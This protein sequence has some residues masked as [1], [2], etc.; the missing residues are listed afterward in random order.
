MDYCL[1]F[2]Q[3]FHM[4]ILYT[5]LFASIFCFSINGQT[6]LADENEGVL[7]F[8][9]IVAK[10]EAIFDQIGRGQG[11]GY[12]QFK[13]WEYWSNRSLRADGTIRSIAEA[14]REVKQF[15]RKYPSYVNKSVSGSYTE[16]GPEEATNTST[17]SSHL[18]RVSAMS[19]DINNSDHIIV[20]SPT[21]GVWRSIDKGNT[22]AT[23]F[24]DEVHLRVF[25]VEISHTN[26]DHYFVGTSI[27]VVY[28]T[29]AGVTWQS[30]NGI[31]SN[32]RINTLTMHPTNPNILFAVSEFDGRV[33]RSTNAG[34]N[35]TQV[36]NHTDRMYDLEFHPTDPSIVYTSGTGAVFKSTNTGVTFSSLSGP[37]TNNGA[38]MM[39]VTADAVDNLY[40]LQA[41]SSGGFG[42]LYVSEDQ[43]DSFSTASDN[44]GNDTN[45]MGYNLNAPNGQAP[46]DMDVVVSPTDKT[47]IHVA[48]TQTFKSTDEGVTW[49]QSTHWVVSNTTLPF[50]HADIDILIYQGNTL[51]AGTD[52]GIFYSTDSANSFVDISQGLSIRE[53]YRIGASET[54]PDRVSGGSQ[55]NGTGVLK[56]GTWFDYLGADGM[57]TL[58]SY[59]N[60]DIMYGSVQFGLLYRSGNG[61]TS[62][63]QTTQTE[64]DGNWVTPVEQDPVNPNTIYQAKNHLW[65]ST[66][67]GNSWTQI[68]NLPVGGSKSAMELAL[69]PSNNQVIYLAYN[70]EI[71]RTTDGGNTWTDISPSNGFSNINYIAVNPTD[72]DELI[73][74]LSGT[75]E[76]YV[77]SLDGGATWSD[78]TTNLPAIGSQCVA[79]E[80]GVNGG[81]YVGMSPGIYF[82]PTG[83]TTWSNV[84]INL[85]NVNV[86]ELEIR[87][88]VLYAA[89][90]GRGLWKI[91]LNLPCPVAFSAANGNALNGV[92]DVNE[93]FETDGVIESTQQID[94]ISTNV[95]YDS[96]SEVLL[97]PGFEVVQGTFHAFIDG[98]GGSML[99]EEEEVKDK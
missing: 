88:S 96:A 40:V 34:V 55:D 25:S 74:A 26:A 39:A 95:D 16:L 76:V 2:P 11:T 58:I 97:D 64:G 21:G 98:C 82:R 35:W 43:G 68:S 60:E 77:E 56:N 65:K 66:N 36:Q 30:A 47:E 18:G 52:G 7:T 87:N 71:H 51:Y 89:T 86:T 32:S 73:L 92:Q 94:G 83:S 5:L 90:Y 72:E 42:G 29:D 93:D 69:A 10:N 57:E 24:D 6:F 78:I 23:I 33:Y 54:D 41:N 27:G 4:K 44:S 12:N 8:S 45:I 85:P 38:M 13:R 59:E 62:A 63:S 81:V 3:T 91:D 84:S 28:S 50:I 9:E 19:I 46:R 48:G 17:W 49:A 22:W 1:I 61:G 37:F 53:F 70:T 67:E 14:D 99:I 20:G 31:N 75:N 80:E 15:N 79:Y